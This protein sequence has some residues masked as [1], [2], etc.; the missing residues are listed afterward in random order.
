MKIQSRTIFFLIASLLLAQSARAQDWPQWRGANRDGKAA[1]FNPP[2]TWPKELTPKWKV[3]VGQGAATPALVGDKLYVFSR[4]NESE[5]IRCLDAASG[6]ELWQDKYETAGATGPASGHSGPRSSP[7][8]AEGKVVTFGV[9]GTLSCYDA[10]TGKKLWRKE[11][12]ANDW[13]T[14][15]TSSS[16][17][18]VNGL[19]IAQLGGK[20]NGAIAAYDLNTGDEKWKWS[21]DGTAYSSPVL[22]DLGGAKAILA[23][24]DKNLLALDSSNGKLLWQMP[25]AGKG[26]GG[27]NAS[28]PVVEGQTII[29]SGGGRG[30]KAIKIDKKG[31]DF[32]AS[33]LWSNPEKSVVFNS[34]VLKNGFIY[35]FTGNN[36]I[37]CID[38]KE[39][40][41]MWSAPLAQQEPAGGGSG[42]RRGGGFGSLID[43]GSVLLLLTPSSELVAFKPTEK[44]YSE[45]ARIKV[46]DSPTYAHPV[47]SGKR[48]F[49][50]D[51]DS[52]ALLT[53]E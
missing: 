41:T 22:M 25:Y 6:K 37:V 9:R 12:S 34:P 10:E 21:G 29:F 45:V 38:A 28:T 3:T 14:F 50:K 31:D 33:D 51:Q 5:I 46:A 47:V 30:T 27:Y 52:V 4:Q 35:E 43:A 8:V 13:P 32:A 44:E 7:T 53:V 17:I 11:G 18:M 39:G 40:K 24:T 2:Q 16:P 15:F 20:E 19:C 23:E 48:I 36:E 42:R 1:K 49:V 26:M